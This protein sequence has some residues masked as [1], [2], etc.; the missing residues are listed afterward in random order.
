MKTLVL[1]LLQPDD[2]IPETTEGQLLL[3][4]PSL[5]I[6][7]MDTNSIVLM[8]SS[9]ADALTRPSRTLSTSSSSEEEDLVGAKLYFYLVYCI[10]LLVWNGC[11][12]IGPPGMSAEEMGSEWSSVMLRLTAADERGLS[13]CTIKAKWEECLQNNNQS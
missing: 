2:V 12:Q 1:A 6:L 7:F 13:Q 3:F 11:Q 4:N 8:F 10:L 5:I 9:P